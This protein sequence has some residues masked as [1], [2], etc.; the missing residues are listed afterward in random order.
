MR[1]LF[2]SD[3]Y[4]PEV[5]APALRTHAHCREWV[6][7]GAEV[8]V[9]S[10]VPNFPQGVPHKGYENRWVQEETVDGVR[11]VRVWSYMAANA[12]FAARIVD[13]V[14]FAVASVIAGLAQDFDVIV[15]TSPQFFTAWAGSVLATIKRRP[16]VFEVRDLWPAS[17]VATGA[18]RNGFAIRLLE[19]LELDLYRSADLI[20][21]VTSAFERNLIARGI[22]GDGICVVPNG[23]NTE[24][25]NSKGG[26]AD[27]SNSEPFK[28]GY[29][30]TMGLAHGLEVL[31]EAA[32]LLAE[33]DVQFEITGDGAARDWLISFAEV[34]ELTNVTFHDPIGREQVPDR[35]Q[36]FHAAVIPLRATKTFTEV[37]PSKIFETAAA[38]VPILLGVRGEAQRL[39]ERYR[40]GIAFEPENPQEL[41]A[42][43]RRLKLDPSLS[44]RLAEGGA[45]LARDFDRRVLARTMLERI[46]ALV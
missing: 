23:V 21:P 32:S 27:R 24:E 43:I 35:L 18:M 14:S 28:V 40:A 42:A 41:A 12:G 4:P 26:V 11:V 6:A 19:R 10:C 15:A 2:L 30:G 20:V 5:N 45:E 22:P 38:G 34:R 29:L 8:T 13:Y 44:R 37:I 33:E 9:I 1:I 7:A 17:I 31:L 3:N 36:A 39:V 46:K 25:W 16:W